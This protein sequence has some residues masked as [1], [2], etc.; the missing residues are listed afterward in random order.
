MN[1][2]IIIVVGMF[3]GA[4]ATIQASPTTQAYGPFDVTFYNNGDTD[5]YFSSQQD[6]RAEQMAVVSTS[7][8]KWSSSITN[9]PGRQIQ[10]H[11]FWNDFPGAILGAS[12]SVRWS[13]G[14]TQWNAP[15]LVWREGIDPGNPL[16][17][18]TYIL[19]DTDAAGNAWNFGSGAPSA[20]EI[21][22]S[23]VV[24]HEIGHSLGWSST[25]DHVFDD[26]GWFGTG[27]GGLTEWDK[28]LVDSLGNKPVSGTQGMP[29]NFNEADDPVYWDGLDAMGY[30]GGPVPVFAPDPFMLGSSLSHLDYDTFPGLMMGPYARTGQMYRTVSGLEWK[31]M[32]DMG[33]DINVI[34]A[35]GAILLGSIGVGLVSW[36]R[37]RRTM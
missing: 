11:V 14:T 24:A 36:L 31:M 6:W 16:G 32:K 35:P 20:L 37:R 4:G 25:Y 23:S 15:E 2:S 7:V 12:G 30:Y 10:M 28:N 3:L 19:Y 26:W 22:F 17:L 21:D 9:V 8:P 29:G 5:G 27:Y 13:N 34:P 1:R 18:D 33:W